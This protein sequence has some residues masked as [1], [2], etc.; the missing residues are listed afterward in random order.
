MLND[1]SSWVFYTPENGP[2][3]LPVLFLASGRKD[4]AFRISVVDWSWR[5]LTGQSPTAWLLLFSHGTNWEGRTITTRRWDLWRGPYRQLKGWNH[6]AFLFIFPFFF[7]LLVCVCVCTCCRFARCTV[8]LLLF[9]FYDMRGG[10]SGS[11]D[12]L[13]GETELPVYSL[14]ASFLFLVPIVWN[15]EK[16]PKKKWPVEEDR[17]LP[18]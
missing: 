14:I 4:S 8:S 9:S 11:N 16:T 12:I 2:L 18:N 3:H 10:S 15:W 17:A 13:L 5:P 6:S 1:G 7:S